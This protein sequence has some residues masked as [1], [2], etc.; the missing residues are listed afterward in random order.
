MTSAVRVN[1]NQGIHAAPLQAG[2]EL[3][4]PEQMIEPLD[5]IAVGNEFRGGVWVR[6]SNAEPLRQRRNRV[7][8]RYCTDMLTTS[9]TGKAMN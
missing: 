3:V 1:D 5:Q 8:D 2:M 9:L 4:T 6:V 7:R